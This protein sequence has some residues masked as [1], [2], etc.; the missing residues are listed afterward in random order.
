MRSIVLL[1]I[2][3]EADFTIRS[4]KENKSLIDI[5]HEEKLH[6]MLGTMYLHRK[7]FRLEK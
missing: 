1:M 7:R 4:K 5:A 6:E 2:D 3:L